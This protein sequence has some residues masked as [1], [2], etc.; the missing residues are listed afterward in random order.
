MKTRRPMPLNQIVAMAV[1]ILLTIVAAILW[2]KDP[3][4]QPNGE[5]RIPW[6]PASAPKS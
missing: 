1:L 3:A 5:S 2:F 6:P 4:H